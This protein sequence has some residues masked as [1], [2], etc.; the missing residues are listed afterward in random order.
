MN[1]FSPVYNVSKS[2][3][4]ETPLSYCQ[5]KEAIDFRAFCLLHQLISQGNVY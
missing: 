1:Q 3:P 2:T 5:L 4:E